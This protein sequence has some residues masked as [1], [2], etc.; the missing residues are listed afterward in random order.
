MRACCGRRAPA[1][2]APR[3]AVDARRRGSRTSR[4][5]RPRSARDVMTT[6]LSSAI[7]RSMPSTIAGGTL[8]RPIAA[9]TTPAPS[10]ARRIEQPRVGAGARVDDVDR[11]RRAAPASRIGVGA[12]SARRKITVPVVDDAERAEAGALERVEL[13]VCAFV[14]S[15]A[16]KMRSDITTIT[17]SPRASRT[18]RDAHRA[19]RGSPGRPSR[20]RSTCASRR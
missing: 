1:K 9:M 14:T 20:G 8:P 11:R 6:G 18:R 16:A 7:Q 12:G 10:L 19:R 3:S 17:P 13:C 4:P 2:I 5:T 15:S